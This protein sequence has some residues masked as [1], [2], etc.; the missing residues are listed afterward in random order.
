MRL[1]EPVIA[2][3]GPNEAGKTALLRAISLLNDERAIEP[4]DKTRK[5]D[6][7]PQI[8]GIYELS[9]DDR[10]A[11]KKA[12][13]AQAEKLRQVRIAKKED[14]KFSVELLGRQRDLEF[15]NEVAQ[16]F[17]SITT[18]AV[19]TSFGA[20][21][22]EKER[23]K[24]RLLAAAAVLRSDSEFFT[25]GQVQQI[26][27]A[28]GEIHAAVSQATATPKEKADGAEFSKAFNE[29]VKT[30]Q[31]WLPA[32]AQATIIQRKP[33]AI[34]FDDPSRDLKPSY[35]LGKVATD[36]PAALRNLAR[37]AGLNLEALKKAVETSNISARTELIE[38]ANEKLQ[39]FFSQAWVQ[40]LVVPQFQIDGGWLHLLVRTLDR[41]LSGVDERSDGLRW[42]IAL[43]AFL[44]F[45][46]QGGSKPVLLVDEAETHLSY[47]A[48]AS[49]MEVLEEQHVAGKIVY[50][51]H[52]AGCLP[53]DLGTG[54]RAVQPLHGERSTVHNG[55]WKKGL[56]L[57]PIYLAMGL[58]PLAFTT[59]R[60]ELIGEG[61]C[62]CIL[63]PTLIRQ[64]V[65]LN[66]LNYQIA[67]GGANVDPLQLGD[68]IS[69]CGRALFV[70][71][72]DQGGEAIRAKLTSAGIS[73]SKIASY[74]DFA[75]A[76]FH[77]E[78]LVSA[79]SYCDAFNAELER[80]QQGTSKITSADVNS[81]GRV[82][83]A[84][85]WCSSRNYEAPS[86]ITVCQRLAEHAALGGMIV[87]PSAKMI[88]TALH[89]WAMQQ[90]R[91][92]I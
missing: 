9:D 30:E 23:R 53:S 1:T 48:Q 18:T 57:S 19:V 58:T 13:V 4:R 85:A 87:D 81:P 11:L 40:S 69:E 68:L 66:R 31:E 43:V 2:I 54:I 50:T 10:I 60:N 41:G 65:G 14:G 63:L 88:L 25:E 75:G 56:G 34:L 74:R 90:F 24:A 73:R 45:E 72:G 22:E 51:T 15:R 44:N 28:A 64:A 55:F 35:E 89:T 76:N 59:A 47:D 83:K 92:A 16:K 62:E 27:Q 29:L 46:H 80:W 52:S 71:D 70:V 67:P 8:I 77:L 33:R 91:P 12:D 17:D 86:K 82:A 32:K 3:V 39:S 78:D 6:A 38:K 26:Q 84:N 7:T 49:L 37:I 36:A 21:S 42:F 79:E 5:T 20:N 61:P